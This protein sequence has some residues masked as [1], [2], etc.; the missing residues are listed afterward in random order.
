MGTDLIPAS[1]MKNEIT[2][3]T[4]QS[5]KWQQNGPFSIANSMQ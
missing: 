1:Q 2:G 5:W 4:D 3:T